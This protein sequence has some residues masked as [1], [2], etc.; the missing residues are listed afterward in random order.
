VKLR[1]WINTDVYYR[2]KVLNAFFSWGKH[3]ETSFSFAMLFQADALNKWYENEIKYFE[4]NGKSYSWAFTWRLLVF[5]WTQ[6]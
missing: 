5:P 2:I 3:D 1:K 4:H 6:I